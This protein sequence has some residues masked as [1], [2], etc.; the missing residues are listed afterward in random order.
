MWCRSHGTQ[1]SLPSPFTPHPALSTPTQGSI[2]GSWLV[3]SEQCDV[4]AH[5]GAIVAFIVGVAVVTVGAVAADDNVN[6][7]DD[8][9]A[10]DISC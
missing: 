7:D 4:A 3:S 9:S 6:D 10:V 8:T 5:A 1:A 2:A